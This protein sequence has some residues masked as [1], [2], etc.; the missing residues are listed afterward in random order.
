MHAY[1]TYRTR[2]N[3]QAWR[4]VQSGNKKKVILVSPQQYRMIV[5]ILI[6]AAT[7]H[8]LYCT[9]AVRPSRSAPK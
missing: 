7:T 3:E 6:V 1:I 4:Q 9:T 5:L 2:R 8:P